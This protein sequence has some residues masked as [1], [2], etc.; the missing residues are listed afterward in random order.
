MLLAA[1]NPVRGS[2]RFSIFLAEVVGR[3]HQVMKKTMVTMLHYKFAL[4]VLAALA[5]LFFVHCPTSSA[6]K[7]YDNSAAAC[8]GNDDTCPDSYSLTG[9]SKCLHPSDFQHR[10]A[11]FFDE[12]IL[13]LLRGTVDKVISNKDAKELVE[14]LPLSDFV[15]SSG[16]ETD[17]KD[18][19]QYTAPVAYAGLG[20]KELSTS[21]EERY[22]KLLQIREK[23]R[24]ATESSLNLCP[25]LLKID[26]TTIAQKTEGG[27]HRA[28]ADNC[29]HYF[30]DKTKTAVCD[31]SRQHPYPKRVAA[32]ILY[33]NDP[34]DGNFNGG[35]FYF[36]NRTHFGEVE[37]SGQVAVETGKMIY[38]TSGVE[39]LHG[40]L[41]VERGSSSE[42]ND[43]GTT[44][45]RRLAI[46][47]W[48][49][50]DQSL[51]EFVPTF[52]ASAASEEEATSSLGGLKPRK[53]YDSND[54][55]AP[56]EL[57]TLPI[58]DRID[59]SSLFQSVGAY[60]VSQQNKPMVG[61]WTIS[62]YG[63]DTLHVLF[64]DHSA[65]FS[66][67]FGVALIEATSHAKASVVVE[68]HTDGSRAASLQYMLQESV[69]LHGLL[70]SFSKV[71]LNESLGGAEEEYLGDEMEK[72][73]NTLPA[74]RA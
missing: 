74:R 7:S 69:L 2:W 60:L 45:P 10:V 16:Y 68:R 31:P 47:M 51:E 22:N 49:V 20:L 1:P 15:E 59:I 54:P 29:V 13:T 46:A 25:G 36:A 28:H 66:L 71:I 24:S 6:A 62:Q 35:E 38:F 17:N 57:F 26:Y 14:L 64:K 50:F 56:K 72:A 34:T 42:Q 67:D 70:D 4:A 73:R 21:N 44:I 9:E 58:P 61:S 12:S 3:Q 30:D 19:A 41:K 11:S 8:D 33:L 48:Y 23:I 40:A 5:L 27:A 55:N 63:E 53:V 18:R 52:Q 37:D 43:D 65:M 32:S 39:N